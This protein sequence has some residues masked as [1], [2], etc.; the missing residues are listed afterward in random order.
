MAKSFVDIG[1]HLTRVMKQS[2]EAIGVYRHPTAQGDGREDLV[3][4]FLAERVGTTFGVT[5]G[6]I[7][8]SLGSTS[9][10]EQHEH[11][12]I[13]YDQSVASCLHLMGQRRIVR[14]ESVAVVLEVK[15]TLN[16]D[17]VGKFVRDVEHLDLLRRFY[18]LSDLGLAMWSLAASP[19]TAAREPLDLP[20]PDDESFSKGLRP[21]DVLHRGEEGGP[22]LV[23]V[24]E[25]IPGLFAYTGPSMAAA[26]EY[27]ERNP[28]LD[29]VCVLGEYVVARRAAFERNARPGDP[30]MVE[31]AGDDAL[32]AFLTLLEQGLQKFRNSRTWVVPDFKRYARSAHP[33]PV[34]T[35]AGPRPSPSIP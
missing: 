25:V 15:S 27:L 28:L 31:V 2:A 30:E 13:V 18:Q 26:Q 10:T 35:R 12:I 3:K 4:D 8:D 21:T 24:P 29:L 9:R 16:A 5:K 19:S 17:G 11:D 6:E 1:H 22:R 7:V 34:A 32:G 33:P 20:K 14:V 23:F